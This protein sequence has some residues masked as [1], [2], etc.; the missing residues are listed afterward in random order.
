M[1]QYISTSLVVLVILFS[2]CKKDKQET[3]APQPDKDLTINLNAAYMPGSK[4]DSAVVLWIVN[5][6]TKTVKMQ[7]AGDKL[8]AP[9]NS[10]T[11][12]EGVLKLQLYSKVQFVYFNSLWL[13]DKQLVLKHKEAISLDGPSG[14]EDIKWIPRVLLHNISMKIYATVGLRPDDPYFFVEDAEKNYNEIWISREYWKTRQGLQKVAGGVWECK[15]NC[16]N[17]KGD[18]LNT[19]FFKFLPNQAGTKK[20]DHIEIVVRYLTEPAGGG[21]LLDMNYTLPE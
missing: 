6:Q 10:L 13:Q 15:S 4:I 21:Y 1:K 8:T 11:E 17:E 7:V 3:P 16:L 9:L 14:F 12:G 20:W 18:I 5:G 2:S 19:E